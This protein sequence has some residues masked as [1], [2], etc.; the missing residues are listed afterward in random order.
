[1]HAADPDAEVEELVSAD[2]LFEDADL[3]D[4]EWA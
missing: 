2:L 3:E 4:A 1:V